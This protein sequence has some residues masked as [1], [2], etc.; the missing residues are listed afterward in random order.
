MDKKWGHRCYG[1]TRGHEVAL[2][3]RER[4]CPRLR[5]D[6]S[7]LDR[8]EGRELA[9]RIVNTSVNTKKTGSVYG[10]GHKTFE[11]ISCSLSYVHSAVGLWCPLQAL[12]KLCPY[13]YPCPCP[14][15][16]PAPDLALAPAPSC[17]LCRP[18]ARCTVLL[19]PT[20]GTAHSS[21]GWLCTQQALC[22]LL[23]AECAHC[24]PCTHSIG[25][26][27]L[28]VGPMHTA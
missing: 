21:L 25:P 16:S 1:Q 10:P 4:D 5:S 6:Q 15:L 12:R 8:L 26:V 9:V 20:A 3:G 14:C 2:R 19:L 11:N 28:T 22:G 24:R 23:R 27:V 17:A 18:Y 13:P 7:R